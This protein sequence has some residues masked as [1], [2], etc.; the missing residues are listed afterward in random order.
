[1]ADC[2]MI[3]SR[4]VSVRLL[5]TLV[6]PGTQWMNIREGVNATVR[7]LETGDVALVKG[8]RWSPAGPILHRSPPIATRNLQRL[9]LAIDPGGPD[10]E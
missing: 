7:S 10:T 9:V 4:N 2:G 1:M 6:G 8:R 3:P 5:Q